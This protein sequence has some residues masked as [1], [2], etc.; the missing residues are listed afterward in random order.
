MAMQVGIDPGASAVKVVV[1]KAKGPIFELHRAFS[2]P[3]EDRD[4]G[5]ASVLEAL[6][7]LKSDLSKAPGARFGVSGKELIIRYTKVP[8]V[9]LWRLKLLMDFE[10]REMAEQAGNSLASDYN[11]ITNPSADAGEE[12]LLVAVVKEEFLNAR[13]NELARTIGE[14]KAAMPGSL[15]L[16]NAYLQAGDLHEGEFV[17]LVDIG[18]QCIEM[19]LE[20]DGELMFARNIAAGGATLTK[21]IA[22][23]LN[24]D[25]ANAEALKE[26]YGNVT[27]R[28]LANYASGREEQVSNTLAAPMAQLNS[29]IQSSVAFAR[30][31]AGLKDLKLGRILISGGSANLAGV[32]D[33]MSAS[34]GCPVERFE[35]DS[36]LD[37][38]ALP[39]EEQ[40]EFEADPGSFAVALGLAVSDSKED[41]FLVD[42]IP[43]PTRKKRHFTS[44]TLWTIAAGILALA[45]LGA[46]YMSLSSQA[47]KAKKEAKV[48]ERKAASTRRRIGEYETLREQIRQTNGKATALDNLTRP[49]FTAA[50]GLRLIQEHAPDTIWVENFRLSVL[51][52]PVDPSKPRGEKRRLDQVVIGG[53]VMARDTTARSALEGLS[54]N[55]EAADERAEAQLQVMGDGRGGATDT[56]FT[57]NLNVLAE[58]ESSLEPGRN[59]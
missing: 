44:R 17:F 53:Q 4:G 8:P 51:S 55:I 5:E 21:A 49:G 39:G 57:M 22:Q 50:R 9:P 15:A 31:Q 35:P 7:Q 43:E 41:A 36:G 34:F 16:F 23:G 19:A 28:H 26:Q 46:R 32:A 18:D 2:I 30:A 11:L 54:K 12:T 42:L 24:T 14:P 56:R 27:P 52:E 38:S 1:G 47:E 59:Q 45:V 29:M 6:G 10:V 3:I 33:A 20:K 13:H 37:L 40:A 25:L 58:P 48:A